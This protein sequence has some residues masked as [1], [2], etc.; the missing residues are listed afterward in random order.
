MRNPESC[1][2][3]MATLQDPCLGPPCHPDLF[4]PGAADR[5]KNHIPKEAATRP[6]VRGPSCNPSQGSL[7]ANE[8]K[9]SIYS[10]KAVLGKPPSTVRPLVKITANYIKHT[11][12]AKVSASL[13][14]TPRFNPFRTHENCISRGCKTGS[15]TLC[16]P[17]AWPGAPLSRNR[18][19][20]DQPLFCPGVER[21]Q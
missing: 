1:G 12:A 8:C 3:S 9:N 19:T 7:S 18:Q 2:N 4:L 5:R 10:L 21:A 11:G 20:G 16:S 15:S 14:S 17:Q 6:R 13:L